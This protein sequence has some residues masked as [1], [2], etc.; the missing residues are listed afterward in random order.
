MAQILA[1]CDQA[2]RSDGRPVMIIARTIKGKGVSFI[3]DKNGW[4]GKTLNK[5]ELKQAL[6]E[7]GEVD[8]S[9]RG[10]IASPENLR[11]S[12]A[13]PQPA[14]KILYLADKPV[15]TRKA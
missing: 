8:K 9:A 1:A 7:L 3:E 14:Q 10:E 11:L 5:E 15:A 4:H 6:T 12:A 2:R 13:Q